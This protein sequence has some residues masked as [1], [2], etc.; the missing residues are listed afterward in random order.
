M[1]LREII[2]QIA[3]LTGKPAQI[4]YRP[5]HPADVPATW[6]DV[7]KAARLLDWRPEVSVEEGLR[8]SVEWYVA[9]RDLARSLDLCDRTE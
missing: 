8:R 7:S 1:L 9:N 5:M 2:D 6:A 4:E 3:E